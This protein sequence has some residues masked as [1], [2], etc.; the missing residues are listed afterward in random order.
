MNNI[1]GM[2]SAARANRVCG[3]GHGPASFTTTVNGWNSF[4]FFKESSEHSLSGRVRVTDQEV[5]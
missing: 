5:P 4:I 2:Y 1:N 3:I